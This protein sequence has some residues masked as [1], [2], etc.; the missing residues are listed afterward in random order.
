MSLIQ[1]DLFHHLDILIRVTF[2]GEAINMSFEEW[3]TSF[4]MSGGLHSEVIVAMLPSAVVTVV[5][6]MISILVSPGVR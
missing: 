6:S 4:R 1:L 2:S 5:H 3:F